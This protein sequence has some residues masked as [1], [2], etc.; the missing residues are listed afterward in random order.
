MP[1]PATPLL[2]SGGLREE[3][4]LASCVVRDGTRADNGMPA[5]A[6]ITCDELVAPQP[7]IRDRTEAA[8]AAK[9]GGG[10]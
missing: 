1:C 5:Y 10:S 2:P 8:L 3:A 9:E 6:D 4:R 7:Y